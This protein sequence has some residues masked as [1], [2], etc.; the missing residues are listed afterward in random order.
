[1]MSFVTSAQRRARSSDAEPQ[2]FAE[3]W[4]LFKRLRREL[5]MRVFRIADTGTFGLTPLEMHI[6]ICGFRA[7]AQR[8]SR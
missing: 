1:M 3:Q 5:F 8:C 7:R 6:L 2:T 4:P